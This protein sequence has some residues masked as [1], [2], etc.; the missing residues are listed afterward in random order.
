MYFGGRLGVGGPFGGDTTVG[1]GAGYSEGFGLV[2]EAGYAFIPYFGLNLFLHWNQTSLAVDSR[3]MDLTENSAYVLLY[4][5]EARG[6]LP[7]GPFVGWASVGIS[8]GTGSLTLASGN[9]GGGVTYGS[10]STVDLKPTPVLGFG[11]EYEVVP[12]LSLGPE[13]RWYV[14]NASEAC[15]EESY[16]GFGFPGMSTKQC[17]KDFSEVTVPDVVFIGIGATYRIGLGG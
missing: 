10:Q 6:I 15:T 9:Q 7:A 14:T 17:T 16:T 3:N 1:P 13:L 12:G 4:G 8:F 5:V 2:A 11:A